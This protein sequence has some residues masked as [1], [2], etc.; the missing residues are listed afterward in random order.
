MM[1]TDSNG[2]PVEV[3]G[4]CEEAVGLLEAEVRGRTYFVDRDFIRSDS[5]A[6]G[7]TWRVSIFMDRLNCVGQNGRT[8][9]EAARKALAEWHGQMARRYETF[10]ELQGDTERAEIACGERDA[11]GRR[12]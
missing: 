1:L 10:V 6:V 4:D 2:K 12:T 7:T 8:P 3:P 9:I 5:G 11:A